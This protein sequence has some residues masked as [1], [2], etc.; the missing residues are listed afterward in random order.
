MQSMVVIVKYARKERET[1]NKDLL[2]K[3]TRYSRNIF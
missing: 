3:G 1:M 2:L